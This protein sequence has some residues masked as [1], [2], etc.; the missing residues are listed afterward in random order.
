[1]ASETITAI[2]VT[3]RIT[4]TPIDISVFSERM[5]DGVN[6]CAGKT[7]ISPFR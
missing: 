1:M 7:T 6:A 2:I 4:T 5:S 3:M